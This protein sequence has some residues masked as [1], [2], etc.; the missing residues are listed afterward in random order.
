MSNY[1]FSVFVKPWKGKPL[2]EIAA[3]IKSLGFDGIELPVRA[4]FDVTPENCAAELPRV[5]A[6][7]ADHGL[8][9]Y[10]VAA[11][12]TD[13]LIRTLGSLANKP[14][15]RDMAKIE[16][17]ETYLEG[18]ARYRARYRALLPVLAG[19]G[20]AIGV[21]HHASRFVTNASGLRRLVEDFDPSLIGA[22]WDPAHCALAGEIPDLAADLLWSHLKMINLKNAIWRMVTGPEAEEVRW[23]RYW[24]SGRMGI[25]S[26]S[27]VATVLR[28][29]GYRGVLTICAEYADEHSVD[30][31]IAE[32]IVFARRV[33]QF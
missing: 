28:Q 26:W 31:L 12:P 13:S 18:E 32:D 2:P 1:K 30:R 23:N 25:A 8:R 6:L 3:H 14:L 27:D 22:V 17:T 21:Q 15:I 29:R 16:A 7:L 11:E 24:T 5:A 19:E 4:G 20:V 10:S 9:I 33:F